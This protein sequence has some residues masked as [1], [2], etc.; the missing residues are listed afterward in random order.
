[1]N[2]SRLYESTRDGET[3]TWIETGDSE[4]AEQRAFDLVEMGADNV[5]LW[6]EDLENGACFAG[7]KWV[8]WM[9]I[10]CLEM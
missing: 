6:V 8:R 7:G 3:Y 10:D 2:H 4:T 5:T 1:M 9:N